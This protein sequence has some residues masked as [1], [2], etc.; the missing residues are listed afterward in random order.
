MQGRVTGR[1]SH[2]WAAWWITNLCVAVWARWTGLDT[3]RSNAGHT[4]VHST[5]ASLHYTLWLVGWHRT[6]LHCTYKALAYTDCRVQAGG[7]QQVPAS[8]LTFILLM[9]SI[10]LLA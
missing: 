7:M 9:F 10:S 4:C 1:A 3:L 5:Q 2:A 6:W 8:F